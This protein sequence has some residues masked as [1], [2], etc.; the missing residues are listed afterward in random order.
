MLM[1]WKDTYRGEIARLYVCG[2][3][4]QDHLEE[5][6]ER[7]YVNTKATFCFVFNLS[8]RIEA[9]VRFVERNQRLFGAKSADVYTSAFGN[10]TL[11]RDERV[12]RGVLVAIT[13]EV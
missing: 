1:T 8:D 13:D 2:R 6:A 5:L 11:R 7:A 12:P 9:Q 4:T 3:I 10:I